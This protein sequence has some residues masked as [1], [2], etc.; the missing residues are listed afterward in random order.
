MD[1]VVIRCSSSS[2]FIDFSSFIQCTIYIRLAESGL[3]PYP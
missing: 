3:V 2:D 1:G